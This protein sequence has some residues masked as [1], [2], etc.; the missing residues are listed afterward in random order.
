MILPKQTTFDNLT[1]DMIDLILSRINT[2][3][4]PKHDD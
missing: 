3:D 2:Y 4:R 1:Q